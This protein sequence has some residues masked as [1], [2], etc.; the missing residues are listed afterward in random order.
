MDNRYFELENNLKSKHI[1]FVLCKSREAVLSEVERL[2]V[3]C[4]TV[5]IGNSQT[6]KAL[7]VSAYLS[8]R[9]KV[10]YDKTN[11]SASEEVKQLKKMALTADGYIAS[12]N[13]IALTGELVNVDHSGNR[14]AAMTYGPEKVIVIVSK[15][16]LVANEKEAIKRAL[17]VATPQNAQ[18][19]KIESP[20]SKGEPCTACHQGVRVCNYLSVI[21]GQN[22]KNRMTVLLLDEELGF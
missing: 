6:L 14:V 16:K 12:S 8:A 5:G 9:D 13:A 3:D 17:S 18:R 20:C 15:N 11:A 10:V 19:A 21:R 22:Q 1:D 4:H 2:T 7:G